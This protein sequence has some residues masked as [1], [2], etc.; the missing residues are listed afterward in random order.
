MKKCLPSLIHSVVSAKYID[1]TLLYN[2]LLA[3]ENDYLKYIQHYM[4]MYRR[5]PKK[6]HDLSVLG[7][8]LLD[9]HKEEQSRDV[10]LNAVMTCKWWKKLNMVQGKIQYETFFKVNGVT[11]LLQLISLDLVDVTIIRDYCAD[12]QLDP[13]IYYKDYLKR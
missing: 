8:K 2:L 10:M 6:L 1:V 3:L 7:I 12:F 4:K 5:Q 13:D 11:R 9:F